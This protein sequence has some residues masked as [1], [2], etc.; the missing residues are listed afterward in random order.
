MEEIII[1]ARE[2]AYL[3]LRAVIEKKAID[4]VVLDV[5]GLVSYA[6]YFVVCSGVSSRQVKALAEWVE[7]S[8]RNAQIHSLSV[9][10]RASGNW[11]LMDYGTVVLHLFHESVRDF[12]DLEGL[13]VDAPRLTI[14]EFSSE[15]N[16]GKADQ[17]E[18]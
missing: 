1:E 18:P 11:V 16:P 5:E 14:P 2:L 17:P 12:Y 15:D 6:D 8:A 4:P 7:R 13:W 9:E 3:L 10:G